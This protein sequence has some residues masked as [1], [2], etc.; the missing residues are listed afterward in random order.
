M[1]SV[2]I[3]FSQLQSFSFF[4]SM[5]RQPQ[6]Q[7]D[8]SVQGTEYPI[9]DE[10]QNPVDAG[11]GKGAGADTLQLS[12]PLEDQKVADKVPENREISGEN[13][14]E[15]PQEPATANP[16]ATTTDQTAGASAAFEGLNFQDS[17]SLSLEIKTREGDTVTIHFDQ[18]TSGATAAL[19]VNNETG[20]G[21][22]GQASLERS[23]QLNFSIEGDLSKKE[24][25]A[26]EHLM[27]RLDKVAEKFF[28]GDMEGVMKRL[29]KLGFNE[30]QLAGFSFDLNHQQSVQ[31]VSAYY[32]TE[33][34]AG[35]D[36]LVRAV[37]FTHDLKQLPRPE[38]IQDPGRDIGKLLSGV[39]ENKAEHEGHKPPEH[40]ILH[41]MEKLMEKTFKLADA[42]A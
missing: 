18:D 19:A 34:A 37:D 38:F 26:I 17:R 27:K 36:D 12:K 23:A 2:N 40:D 39:I 21:S 9:G 8:S 3:Q 10:Q 13:E 1:I 42:M 41:R 32:G 33:S 28:A 22:A 11:A 35:T 20:S 4:G 24:H 5:P 25:K 15:E 31:A 14:A 30:Q 7:A 29:G 16:P 6:V